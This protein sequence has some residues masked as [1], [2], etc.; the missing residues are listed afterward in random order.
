MESRAIQIHSRADSNV[1]LHVIPGHFATSHS[2]INY[3]VDMTY[4][5][6]RH[7]DASA[8]AVLLAEPYRNIQ[9]DTIVCMDNCEVVGAF[10]AEAL[11]EASYSVNS[12]KN[13]SV[14]TPEC[15]ADHNMIFRDNIQREIYGKGVLILLASTT[16]G[17]T[18]RR[19]KECIQY[20]GGNVTGISSIF[21]AVDDVTGTP[22][23][24]L[25]SIE[26][27]PAYSTYPYNKCPYCA[28]RQKIDALV[29]GHGYSKL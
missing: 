25:F 14:V 24:N 11:S 6:T 10:L 4:I 19:L 12:G 15:D 3:Y 18:S 1:T 5:K 13:I 28:A 26:D 23:Y 7:Q 16:T 21:S 29:N 2:H 20:Y 22:V 9:V 17:K 8:A 27:V